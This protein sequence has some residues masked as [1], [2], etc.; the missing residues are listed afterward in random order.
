[1]VATAGSS[2]GFPACADI[3]VFTAEEHGEADVQASVAP[4]VA[5]SA[6][7]VGRTGAERA[8]HDRDRRSR[9][10][11]RPAEPWFVRVHEYPGLGSALAW[12]HPVSLQP[13]DLLHRRFDIAIADGQLTEAQTRALASKLMNFR[14]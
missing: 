1:M 3:E 11:P 10:L 6:D 13:G 2:G 8:S 7:F 14:E 12:D 5:W 9:Q 4:W